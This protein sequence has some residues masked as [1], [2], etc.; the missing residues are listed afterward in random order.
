MKCYIQFF[1]ESGNHAAPYPDDYETCATL[2][3]ARAAFGAWADEVASYAEPQA[4]SAVVYLGEPEGA[5]P[6]DCYPDLTMSVGPRGG[7]IVSRA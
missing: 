5:F 3:D 7:I 2:A 4:A 6:C 1:D